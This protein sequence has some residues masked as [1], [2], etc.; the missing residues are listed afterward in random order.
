M[1]GLDL[2][3]RQSLTFLPRWARGLQVFANGS[4]QRSNVPRGQLAGNDFNE[5]PRNAAWGFSFTRPRYNLR[6][7][8]TWRADQN[9]GPVTGLGIEPDTFNYT[10]GYT[11]LDVLGE[12]TLRKNLAVFANLRNIGDIPD[13]GTTVGPTT[14]S[15]ATLRFVERYGSLWTIGVKG[16]F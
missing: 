4:L 7:N 3:Y 15:H 2:S 10:P 8:W 16:S 1:E 9:Q 12:F 11:K 14:P 13:K 5:I 6:L